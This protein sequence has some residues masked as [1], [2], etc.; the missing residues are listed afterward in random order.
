M[1]WIMNCLELLGIVAFSISGAVEA[2]KKEMDFLGVVVLGLVTAVGGGVIRDIVIGQ[3]PPAAFENPKYAALA[4]GV[5][6]IAFLMGVI[7]SKP[8]E[9]GKLLLWNHVLLLSDAVGLGAFT[10]LGIRSTQEKLGGDN[11]ALLLFV[12]V[13]TGVGGGILRDMFAGNVPYIFRKHV[14]ATASI[15]GAVS[16]LL[17]DG[18]GYT[19]LA[20]ICS[21]A[22]VLALRVLAAHFQ[23]NLPRVK[24]E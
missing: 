12:G 10:I 15:A 20:V 13:I 24:L 5:A 17:L 2:M 1:E 16:Y 23:W 11:I 21:L 8:K 6:A 9:S 14:Y 7:F 4:L 18:A 22:L 3:V 19:Q